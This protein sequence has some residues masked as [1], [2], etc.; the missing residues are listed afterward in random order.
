M[1]IGR[2]ST[3]HGRP[4]TLALVRGQL[5]TADRSPSKAVN[6]W[7]V[8]N[9]I[10]E[11]KAH[12]IVIAIRSAV[13]TVTYTDVHQRRLAGFRDL[14][15]WADRGMTWSTA[16][17]GATSSTLACPCSLQCDRSRRRCPVRVAARALRGCRARCFRGGSSR[18]TTMPATLA[19]ESSRKCVALHQLSM[20]PGVLWVVDRACDGPRENVGGALPH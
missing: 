11:T 17:A 9:D 1:Q 10:G 8:F 3:P 2:V 20:P 13:V 19:T 15:G 6:K 16:G 4:M 5:A 18:V 12:I 14:V 7:K